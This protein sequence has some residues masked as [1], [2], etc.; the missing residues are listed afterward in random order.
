MNAQRLT[1]RPYQREAIDAVTAAWDEGMKRPALVLSTGLGKTVIFSHLASEYIER[2]GR[3]VLILVHRD[4]LA[5]QAMAKIREIA[6][7]L[8]VGKVKAASNQTTRDVVVASVQTLSR[9]SRLQKLLDV[10]DNGKTVGLV[11]TDECFPA[12]TLVDGRPIESLT[13]G[14]LVPTWNETTGREEYRPVVATM[15]KRPASLVKVSLADGSTFVCT[16][17]HPILTDC[18]WCPAGMLSRDA[19]VVSFTHDAS[20]TT[21]SVLPMRDVLRDD[22][23]AAGELEEVGARI[24]WPDV[25]AGVPGG[26][27]ETE[28]GAPPGSGLLPMWVPGQS[29]GTAEAPS[30]DVADQGSCVLFGRL[31]GRVG[32]PGRFEAY[33]QDEP[34]TRIGTNAGAQPHALPRDAREDVRHAQGDGSQAAV[35]GREREA[36]TGASTE[37]CG[38]LGLADGIPRRSPRRGTSV[39][40]Q[41]GHRSSDDE[42]VRGSGRGVPFLAGAPSLRPKKGR[43][44]VLTRVAG[45]Q[46]LEPGRDGTYGGVCPDGFVYNLEVDTTHTYLIGSGTVVHNCHHG[47]A[48]SYQKIYDALPDAF[49]LG[50]TATLARGDGKGLGSVWDDVVYEKSVTWGIRKGFLSPVKGVAVRVPELDLSAVRSSRGDYQANDLGE[51]LESSGVLDVIPQAYAEHASGRPGVVFLPT[52]ETAEHTAEALDRAGIRTAVISGATPR[53]DRLKI[54]EDYRTGRVQVLANCMVLTEGFDAPHT[55]CIVVARPTQS[56]PLYIQMVGRGTRTYPGKTDCLVLDVVGAG[57]VNKLMTLVDLEPG[58]FGEPKLCEVC[59]R[60]PC[61]CPC[62]GCGGPRPCREC[63]PT[64]EL[65]ADRGKTEEVDLFSGSSQSWLTTPAGLMFIPAGD[66]EVFLWSSEQTGLWDVC[67]A[68]KRG[69]WEKIRS[70]LTLGTAQAWAETEADERAPF[71]VRKT[72]SWRRKKPSEAQL[73]FASQLRID[74][75]SDVRSG[76]LGNLISVAM[77]TRK[78]DRYMSR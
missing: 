69:K 72:A 29:L 36:G 12:G 27:S 52:V 68:P 63:N 9:A 38:V 6:P 19:L 61:V 8:S 54:L 31:P 50:V 23:Y 78:F 2:T 77:A 42:S 74:L 64:G 41:G 3:Q 51:A 4:E 45:V 48:P 70:G 44:A 60:T 21:N 10:T 13:P 49:H 18:G 17:N 37:T 67:Y 35:S 73:N 39:S 1:L 30:S 53:E 16:P 76:D 24:L 57:H 55:S 7:G 26:S 65:E 56:N 46:V 71:N 47:L 58:M 5:D 32:V 15:R 33:G 59:D 22:E 34:E 11:I 43:K 14:S 28:G 40:L 66:G 75:P 20:A 25:R 62:S